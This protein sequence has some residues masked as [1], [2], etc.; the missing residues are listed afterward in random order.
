VLYHQRKCRSNRGRAD[1][2]AVRAVAVVSTLRLC[3]P[4]AQ[5]EHCHSSGGV[6]RAAGQRASATTTA[7]AG[8]CG[9]RLQGQEPHPRGARRHRQ[10]GRCHAVAGVLRR[11]VRR[12][13]FAG[14]CSALVR[15]VC[16]LLLAF[17]RRERAYCDR[18]CVAAARQNNMWR[19]RRNVAAAMVDS[20]SGFTFYSDTEPDERKRSRVVSVAIPGVMTAGSCD[21]VEWGEAA[22]SKV[23]DASGFVFK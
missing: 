22:L 18:A 20:S 1:G 16:F 6:G 11:D 15:H 2:P 8:D 5:V 9:G 19:G 3:V 4:F 7:A 10:R 17:R 21:F 12:G 14:R 23:P 13:E